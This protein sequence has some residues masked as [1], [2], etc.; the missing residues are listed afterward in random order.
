MMVAAKKRE[1][2]DPLILSCVCVSVCALTF[3]KHE[4]FIIIHLSRGPKLAQKNAERRNSKSLR[5]WKKNMFF[6]SSPFIMPLDAAAEDKGIKRKFHNLKLKSVIYDVNMSL[7]L[8]FFFSHNPL[9]KRLLK[10]NE[11]KK[12]SLEK[13]DKEFSCS[14]T[15]GKTN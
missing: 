5:S 1:R 8:T 12:Q 4:N 9:N 6:F 7:W 3:R 11:K 10:K 15:V 13:N 2:E 14:S